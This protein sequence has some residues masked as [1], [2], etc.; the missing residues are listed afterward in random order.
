[1]PESPRPGDQPETTEWVVPQDTLEPVTEPSRA[2]RT[3]SVVAV[4]GL[5]VRTTLEDLRAVARWL[6]DFDAPWWVAGG[7][8]IDLWVGGV[9]RDHSDIEI[10][11]LREDQARL[12]AYCGNWP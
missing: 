10:S 5:P 7:W 4:G 6:G 1:M 12:Y 2:T 11:I 8:A 9:S 3:R